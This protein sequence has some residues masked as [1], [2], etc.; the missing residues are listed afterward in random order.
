MKYEY[1]HCFLDDPV[2]QKKEAA[3][4]FFGEGDA[5]KMIE[6]KIGDRVCQKSIEEVGTI[7]ELGFDGEGFVEFDLGGKGWVNKADLCKMEHGFEIGDKVAY[8]GCDSFGE[9]LHVTHDDA[10]IKMGEELVKVNVSF[11]HKDPAK[12]KDMVEFAKGDRIYRKDTKSVGIIIG[13]NKYSHEFFAVDFKD[14]IIGGLYKSDLKKV[15]HDFEVGDVVGDSFYTGKKS[16]IGTVIGMSHNEITIRYRG[17]DVN[18]IPCSQAVHLI[19]NEEKETVGF[20][21]GD[22]V[23]E[24]SSGIAGTVQKL[25]KDGCGNDTMVVK[26]DSGMVSKGLLKGWRKENSVDKYRALFKEVERQEEIIK[27]KEDGKKNR[28]LLG[29]DGD[30]DIFTHEVIAEAAKALTAKQKERELGETTMEAAKMRSYE[31]VD[32]SREKAKALKICEEQTEK[33]VRGEGILT[34]SSKPKNGESFEQR[35]ADALKALDVGDLFDKKEESKDEL[36]EN[37]DDLT[38]ESLDKK[39]RG[40][41]EGYGKETPEQMKTI[42]RDSMSAFLTKCAGRGVFKNPVHSTW[43]AKFETDDGQILEMPLP[44]NR[45]EEDEPDEYHKC[46]KLTFVSDI[47]EDFSAVYFNSPEVLGPILIF[48]EEGLAWLKD[49]ARHIEGI[50]CIEIV[51]W[52]ARPIMHEIPQEPYNYFCPSKCEPNPEWPEGRRPRKVIQGS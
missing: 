26:E 46:H 52:C 39:W 43:T 44:D 36:R 32:E 15:E 48:H 51:R 19:S 14:G 4:K 41:I 9:I 20:I 11:L 42:I 16:G 6:F 40:K 10:T 45:W 5:E 34:L 37:A 50:H 25:E 23:Y 2:F 12:E 13:E 1:I 24:E 21:V 38:G 7:K 47:A 35:K 49:M 28:E 29:L 27:L 3:M 30:G 22:R 17:G 31:S 33:Y 18:T 8:P